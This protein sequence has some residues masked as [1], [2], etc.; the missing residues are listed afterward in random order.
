MREKHCWTSWG[1][2]DVYSAELHIGSG[3][4]VDISKKAAHLQV[5]I[6]Q[7]SRTIFLQVLQFDTVSSGHE[8]HWQWIGFFKSPYSGWNK[9]VSDVLESWNIRLC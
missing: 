1:F 7:D 5:A 2:E 6:M 4:V 9:D 3:K 8:L